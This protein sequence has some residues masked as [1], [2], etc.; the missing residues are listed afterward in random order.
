M[1][2]HRGLAVVIIGGQGRCLLL[3]F[4]MTPVVY[5]LFDDVEAQV[6]RLLVC[7]RWAPKRWRLRSV[8]AAPRI[9]KAPVEDEARGVRSMALPR[10]ETQLIVRTEATKASHD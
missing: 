2:S 6:A 8:P 7:L 5:S 10:W 1:D 3:T 4:L 9:G